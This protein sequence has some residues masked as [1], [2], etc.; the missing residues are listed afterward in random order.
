[1]EAEDLTEGSIPPRKTFFRRSTDFSYSESGFWG[2]T[3]PLV[4]LWF[5]LSKFVGKTVFLSVWLSDQPSWSATLSWAVTLSHMSIHTPANHVV[6]TQKFCVLNVQ[7]LAF[8]PVVWLGQNSVLYTW[9]LK[10]SPCSYII[11]ASDLH[12]YMAVA[13]MTFLQGLVSRQNMKSWRIS[14]ILESRENCA[15]W[16]NE[17]LDILP[18]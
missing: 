14:R 15:L 7:W 4:E 8:A 17:I 9:S 16:L 1:M 2:F 18:L 10:T 5:E 12:Q 3:W 13:E 6:I 11:L